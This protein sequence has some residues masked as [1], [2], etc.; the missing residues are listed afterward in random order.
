VKS[1]LP[2]RFLFLIHSFEQA[3]IDIE[4]A[5]IHI[6]VQLYPGV[7]TNNGFILIPS[8]LLVPILPERAREAQS[9]LPVGA[10]SLVLFEWIRL[11][12]C[13]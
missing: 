3:I 2:L 13:S 9:G 6:A 1:D 12:P 4:Q 7:V 10:G 8:S 11:S 5:I